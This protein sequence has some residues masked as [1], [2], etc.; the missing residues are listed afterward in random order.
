VTADDLRSRQLRLLLVAGALGAPLVALGW[1]VPGEDGA[2]SPFWGLAGL[3]L[4]VLAAF[5]VSF[6]FAIRALRRGRP[7]PLA[8]T[9]GRAVWL[10][11]TGVMVGVVGFDP[12]SGAVL[13]E[14]FRLDLLGVP[15]AP[16]RAAAALVV[17]IPGAFVTADL[18]ALVLARPAWAAS[19]PGFARWLAS[20]EP[21]ALGLAAA[22]TRVVAAFVGYVGLMAAWITFAAWRG[23]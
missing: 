16:V 13:D 6:E 19:A 7:E 23:V 12:A 21:A 22:R 5:S 8:V 11:S 10:L 15:T 17:M 20:G 18:M 2:P 3:L 4:G 9:G 14:A 1:F